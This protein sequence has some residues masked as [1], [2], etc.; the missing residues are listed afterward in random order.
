MEEGY[1]PERKG[2]KDSARETRQVG[3][4]RDETTAGRLEG[5]SEAREEKRETREAE[6]ATGQGCLGLGAV[7]LVEDMDMTDTMVRDVDPG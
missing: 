4:E 7:L 2:D 3:R 6:K 5:K 1:P